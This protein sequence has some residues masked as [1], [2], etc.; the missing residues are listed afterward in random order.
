MKYV[1]LA[2]ALIWA[3]L[4]ATLFAGVVGLLLLVGLGYI[5]ETVHRAW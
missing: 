3:V 2:L 5:V 1:Y 4:L